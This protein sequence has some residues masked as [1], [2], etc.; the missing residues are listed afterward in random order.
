MYFLSRSTGVLTAIH[1]SVWAVWSAGE[2]GSSNRRISQPSSGWGLQQSPVCASG[3]RHVSTLQ[4][5]LWE[6]KAAAQLS[7][8]SPLGVRLT[9]SCTTACVCVS[10]EEWTQSHVF[11]Q[12]CVKQ[13]NILYFSHTHP[14]AAPVGSQQLNFWITVVFFKSLLNLFHIQDL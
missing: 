1:H 12:G 6:C 3:R 2:E 11:C 7:P 8:S 10:T 4:L 14:S 5:T 13:N 9:G